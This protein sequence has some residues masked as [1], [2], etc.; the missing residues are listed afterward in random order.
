MVEKFKRE[1]DEILD[2]LLEFKPAL[3]SSVGAP[4]LFNWRSLFDFSSHAWSEFDSDKR[5]ALINALAEK[6][7]LF[8]ALMT[9]KNM[10]MEMGRP[11]I[12][13][14]AGLSLARFLEEI[15]AYDYSIH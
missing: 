4:C 5:T 6:G 14:A 2:E 1:L 15:V 11:D 13:G 3:I 9:F 12:A 10:Y 8:L 7:T